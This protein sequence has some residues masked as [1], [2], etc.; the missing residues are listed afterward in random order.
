MIE[1]N[2]VQSKEVSL[3]AIGTVC[4]GVNYT[5]RLVCSVKNTKARGEFKS[6]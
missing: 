6:V 5:L 4:C 3:E 2:E 1:Q